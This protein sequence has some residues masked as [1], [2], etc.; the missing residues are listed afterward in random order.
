[1]YDSMVFMIV[2]LGSIWL[3]D[4]LP[5]LNVLK[6]QWLTHKRAIVDRERHVAPKK[7]ISKEAKEGKEV[8]EME[9]TK[10]TKIIDKL[11]KEQ[12]S[13]STRQTGIDKKEKSNKGDKGNTS[14][15]RGNASSTKL[16]SKDAEERGKEAQNVEKPD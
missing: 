12:H 6:E 15:G 11:E 8:K 5:S 14:E 2:K 16:E 1:M 7:E 9:S 13:V 3:S 10:D 4:C